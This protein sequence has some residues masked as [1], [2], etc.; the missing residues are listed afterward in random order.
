[1]PLMFSST[2]I[3][4][5]LLAAPLQETKPVIDNNRV[6]VREVRIP[7]LSERRGKPLTIGTRGNDV[8]A[9]DLDRTTAYFVPKGTTHPVPQR[10]IVIEL[11]NVS[12][13]TLAAEDTCSALCGWKQEAHRGR[14]RISK[15]FGQSLPVTKSRCSSAS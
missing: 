12:V 1:M 13:P 6:R 4:F 8:V 10:G 15:T 3:L 2:F 9:I 11:K 7:A 5:F 14:S